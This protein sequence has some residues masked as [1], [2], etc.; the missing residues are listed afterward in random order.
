MGSLHKISTRIL[1]SAACSFWWIISEWKY[2]LSWLWKT[3][4]TRYGRWCRIINALSVELRSHPVFMRKLEYVHWN[5]VK[6]GMCK[7][8]EAYKYSSALLYEVGKESWDFLSHYRDWGVGFLFV[9]WCFC[10]QHGAAHN[11]QQR[12]PIGLEDQQ[13]QKSIICWLWKTA[14]GAREFVIPNQPIPNNAVIN[15]V[16]WV[17]K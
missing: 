10:Q 11:T 14:G 7:L 17:I 8:P 3:I 4:F 1:L 16:K 12:P 5:P 2:L 15:L 9:C 6:A 13:G